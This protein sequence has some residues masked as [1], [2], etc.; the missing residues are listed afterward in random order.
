MG[1]VY[2]GVNT[3]LEKIVCL[4]ILFPALIQ[5]GHSSVARFLREARSI[6]R[7]E[8][9]NIVRIYDIEEVEGIYFIVMEYIEGKTLAQ[10]LEDRDAF[11]VRETLKI[12]VEIAEALSAAHRQNIIHRD[13]KPANI[14]LENGT[15]KLT[16]FGLARF[17]DNA[18]NISASNEI[19][20]TPLYLP[21][22]YIR[23]EILDTRMDQYS[24]GV[25]L[26][27][28]L[29][30]DPPYVG[31][32]PV[33]ILQ[34]HLMAPVPSI[35]EI[36]Q[37]V[38][39]ELDEIVQK[40]LA[41]DRDQ[42]FATTEELVSRLHDCADKIAQELQETTMSFSPAVVTALR[43]KI[44]E[45]PPHAEADRE[46]KIRILV[47]DDSHTMCNAICRILADDRKC[48]VVGIAYN[49]KEA[50]EKTQELKP[51]VITL[52][53]NMPEMDGVTTV[54]QIMIRCPRPV[55]MLSGFTYDGALTTLECLACGAVD[56]VWKTSRSQQEQ[57]KRELEEK[58]HSAARIEL[59]VLKKPRIT[60]SFEIHGQP[61]E[62]PKPAL[63][64]VVMGADQGGYHAYLKI[65][66]FI[67]KNI[68]CAIVMV[69]EM[70]DELVDAFSKYLNHYSRVTVKEVDNK[71][72]LCEGVC[73]VVNHLSPLTIE[74][75]PDGPGYRILKG[76]KRDPASGDSA[77]SV[78]S[79]ALSSA[80]K[81]CNLSA[82][83][84]ALTGRTI[85]AVA[86]LRRI[87]EN[88]GTVLIQKPST[89]L[90]PETADLAI[91]QGL[92]DKIV[93]DID[94]PSVLWHLLKQKSKYT[95]ALAMTKT[96]SQPALK[97]F[98]ILLADSDEETGKALAEILPAGGYKI[99][100][101]TD[102]LDAL[103]LLAKERFDAIFSAVDLPNLDGIKL[104]EMK[105][106]KEIATPM[107]FLVDPV[108]TDEVERLTEIGADYLE[109]PIDGHALLEKI[110]K[111][112]M[113]V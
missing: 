75:C 62:T 106:D 71:E 56:F 99:T 110:R 86:G 25:T 96:K 33:H 83:G 9:R 90:Y 10:L 61:K 93:P 15:V 54:K 18:D 48:Q 45:A 38:P 59:S 30:G 89:C 94:I 41:K 47:V 19:L 78:F 24:F 1:A 46:N 76:P 16:D 72:P 108:K 49:G 65:I 101:T 42:R 68:P 43:D 37:D 98:S 34:Q 51:D 6:A 79:Q 40:L 69:Q 95:T 104:L 2:Q 5:P 32:N 66:P 17:T 4:K 80:A 57:F 28:M 67:P 22:E 44:A 88:G 58:I 64:V 7:L 13:I 102:G 105:D 113:P 77:E 52:D 111:L 29:S 103:F 50:L 82:I 97:R 92:A 3:S 100:S 73:Y 91:S 85:D 12:S 84:I 74:R 60:K 36:R 31:K 27:H 20:G 87:K 55:I 35:R 23:G 63:W 109:K 14:M 21:P 107:I 26:Y 11:P 39:E 81:T 8:H 70:T 112:S 53:F